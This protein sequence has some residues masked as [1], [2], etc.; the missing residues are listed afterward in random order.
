MNQQN[1]F[2]FI[3]E[4]LSGELGLMPYLAF[5]IPLGG[6]ILFV[7]LS[8][9][10]WVYK[11]VYSNK[12]SLHIPFLARLLK[13]FTIIVVVA[14]I[15]FNYTGTQRLWQMLFGS[16]VIVSAVMGFAAQDTLRDM[17]AGL[18]IS[19]FKPFDIGDRLY[20]PDVP[21]PVIVEDITIRHVVLRAK[22]GMHFIIPNHQINTRI[23]T[24][25]N[26]DHGPRAT[27]L[28][29][30][31][32]YSS[33][34]ARA[35]Q[36]MRQAAADCPYTCPYNWNN[37]DLKGYGDAYITGFGESAFLLEMTI[38]SEPGT[39]ND[40]A[41][42]NMYATIAKLFAKNNIEIPYNYVNVVEREELAMF[43]DMTKQQ[44]DE[45]KRD[46]V[47]K[48]DSVVLK[49]KIGDTVAKSI[50][51]TQKF[52]KFHVFDSSSAMT[53]ELLTEEL[54]TFA[55]NVAGDISGRFWIEGNAKKVKVC[56][57]FDMTL[58][59]QKQSELL[60]LSSDGENAGTRSIFGMIH[61]RIMSGI[62]GYASTT[63]SLSSAFESGGFHD[64]LEKLL[65][66]KMSDD[67]RVSI[68][69]RRVEIVVIKLF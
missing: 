6:L 27:Y 40:L 42:S 11:K 17:L 21:K 35:I 57:R 63:F 58:S 3:F 48:S 25:T 30:P 1:V 26:W 22:D 23:I 55:T 20:V 32:S 44:S 50:A 64:D 13:L 60:T 67:V 4:A 43:A 8:L 62:N 2:G 41:V 51:E 9:E 61:D 28:S 69:G 10:Q 66:S 15:I 65:I 47:T 5:A 59:I 39:D 19:I 31:V 54:I 36:L 33:N 46:A 16:T 29:I 37:K 34:L 7:A 45:I 12:K 53:L 52:C 49:T 18:I 14:S 38:W 68:R 56:V 24:H